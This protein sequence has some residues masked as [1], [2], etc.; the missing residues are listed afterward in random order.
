MLE[1]FGFFIIGFL[2]QIVDGAIGMAYGL[3]S[4]AILLSIG[5]S[6]IAASASIHTSEIVTTGISGI[7]HAMFK[8]I[9]YTLF[10]RLLLPGI[11][12]S[13]IGAYLLTRIPIDI[14]KPIISVYLF[15]LG[16]IIIYKAFKTK[17][18][19][20]KI[21]ILINKALEREKPAHHP[22]RIIPLG[23]AGGFCDAIGGG[24]WGAF[25]TSSLLAQ[26]DEEPRF[27]VGTANFAEFL[28]AMSSSI[29]FFILIGISHWRIVLGLISGGA[30][31]API[32]AFS[33]KYIPIR[34][35]LFLTGLLVIL[36]SLQMIAKLIF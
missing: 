20:E 8:N 5:I 16:M 19:M 1:F 12:G 25:I 10:R 14:I 2:A 6:P 23:L 22:Y 24:G 7:A 33:L 28:I 9:D 11:I 27:T 34:I 15:V 4:M 26:D 21:K 32:A 30:I 29:T 18:W 13:I 36:V 17:N 35:L 31:A 3:I